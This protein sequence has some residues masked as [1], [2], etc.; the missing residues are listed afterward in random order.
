MIHQYN[1]L[2][3]PSIILKIHSFFP[4]SNTSKNSDYKL[5]RLSQRENKNSKT[6]LNRK[7]NSKKTNFLSSKKKKKWKK[8]ELSSTKRLK[9]SNK[10]QMNL[11]LNSFSKRIE[12]PLLSRQNKN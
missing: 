6:L 9:S 8:N 11:T 7:N 3:N 4:T 12:T 10:R 5:L 2:R 1:K